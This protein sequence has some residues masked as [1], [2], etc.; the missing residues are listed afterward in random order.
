MAN[1][2][3]TKA[4]RR[5]LANT[6]ERF[7]SGGDAA[8][9]HITFT[10]CHDGNCTVIVTELSVIAKVCVTGRHELLL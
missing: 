4:C 1:S 10:T 8:L 2:R 3:E 6:T 5:H 7:V 9:C